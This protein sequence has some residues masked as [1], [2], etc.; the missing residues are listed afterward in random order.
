MLAM[1]DD[2]ADRLQMNDVLFE[3]QTVDWLE[4]RVAGCIS[5]LRME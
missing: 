1:L 4:R 3:A 5:G 2:I